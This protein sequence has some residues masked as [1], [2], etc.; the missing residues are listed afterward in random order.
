M[1]NL[2][3]HSEGRIVYYFSQT[4]DIFF[5]VRD[6]IRT[7]TIYVFESLE[8][9]YRDPG[10]AILSPKFKLES[11]ML[12]RN[13]LRLFVGLFESDFGNNLFLH[14]AEHTRIIG[15]ADAFE[16]DSLFGRNRFFR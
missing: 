13:L 6:A 11:D 7:D 1:W 10:L 4:G 9:K 12:R 14:V 16:I 8:R 15:K 5:H 2:T 3:I